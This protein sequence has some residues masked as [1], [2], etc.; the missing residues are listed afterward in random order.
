MN[1]IRRIRIAKL[2]N[3]DFIIDP[4]FLKLDL[5]G[6]SELKYPDFIYNLSSPVLAGN[7]H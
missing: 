4:K 2:N 6:N 1:E 7:G 5:A 3:I